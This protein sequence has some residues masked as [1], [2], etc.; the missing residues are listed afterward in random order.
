M[1]IKRP[2]HKKRPI[3][4]WIITIYYL[5]SVVVGLQ[6]YYFNSLSFRDAALQLFLCFLTFVG[7][8]LFFFLRRE[9]FYFFVII[10][11]VLLA[12]QFPAFSFLVEW[13]LLG[14][15][16]VYIQSLDNTGYLQGRKIP[17]LRKN[18]SIF[19][20]LLWIVPTKLKATVLSTKT[21][22]ELLQNS[23]LS[24]I[25]CRMG[26]LL[27]IGF[28]ITVLLS[29]SLLFVPLDF[30]RKLYSLGKSTSDSKD[31]IGINNF[32]SSIMQQIHKF[33]HEPNRDA[34]TVLLDYVLLLKIKPNLDKRP[35][36]IENYLNLKALFYL[37][38]SN[39]KYKRCEWIRTLLKRIKEQMISESDYSLYHQTIDQPETLWRSSWKN[40]VELL[41]K[42]DLSAA[43]DNVEKS[44]YLLARM[45][46]YYSQQG[47]DEQALEYFDK[48]YQLFSKRE[49]RLELGEISE[50]LEEII[51]GYISLQKNQEAFALYRQKE[52]YVNSANILKEFA[53]YRNFDYAFMMLED[54]VEDLPDALQY[55]AGGYAGLKQ[56]YLT[57]DQMKTLERLVHEYQKKHMNKHGTFRK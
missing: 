50:T 51:G 30:Q 44:P 19:D 53:K 57:D 27:A 10:F 13:I 36:F 46:G 43:L 34:A 2:E 11:V 37:Y 7:A 45:G 24:K 22:M 55:L 8:C 6:H 14:F 12:L 21:R 23:K 3:W 52:N 29:I 9:A 42:D 31:P 54:A 18:F 4:V 25:S 26:K 47:R 41:R 40:I 15:V 38:E 33:N 28:L 48:A 20:M 16:L 39:E 1:E 56:E 35:L 49:L 5:F 32:R 17:F